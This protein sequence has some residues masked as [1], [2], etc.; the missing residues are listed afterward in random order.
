MGLRHTGYVIELQHVVK[1]RASFL[2]QC[3]AGV[4]IWVQ[5]VVLVVVFKADEGPLISRAPVVVW[6][7]LR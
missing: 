1:V 2:L 6:K 3:L 4:R 5:P 7:A